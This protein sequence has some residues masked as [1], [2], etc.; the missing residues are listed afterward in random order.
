V[1]VSRNAR[2][3]TDREVAKAIA[4]QLPDV[5]LNSHHGTMDIRVRNRIFATFPA[6]KKTMV[7]KC[8]ADDLAVMT[9]ESPHIFARIHGENWVEVSLDE[10]DRPTLETLLVDAWSLA[11]PPALRKQHEERLGRSR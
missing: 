11:A 5:E 1:N 3:R 7:L 10:I 8:T 4:L 2:N 9:R 6:Q